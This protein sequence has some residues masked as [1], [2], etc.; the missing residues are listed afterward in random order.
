MIFYFLTGITLTKALMETIIFLVASSDYLS[1]RGYLMISLLCS[2][3]RKELQEFPIFLKSVRPELYPGLKKVYPDIPAQISGKCGDST[4]G[5]LKSPSFAT[6][7]GANLSNSR[8]TG[9]D[10]SLFTGLK[11]LILYDCKNLVE[12]KIPNTVEKLVL[13]G[14]S[15]L[16]NIYFTMGEVLLEKLSLDF[17][18][19]NNASL[20]TEC[21]H[22]KELFIVQAPVAYDLQLESCLI[23]ENITHIVIETDINYR[24]V[25]SFD[26]V[27]EYVDIVDYEYNKNFSNATV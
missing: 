16:R 18:N 20:F 1:Q 8:C 25:T 3:M 2:G 22:L 17:T 11:K 4:I 6:V 13:S 14:S 19:F 5:V 23:S 27:C 10:F 15:S 7:E 21:R 24:V 26:D 12:V 9:M